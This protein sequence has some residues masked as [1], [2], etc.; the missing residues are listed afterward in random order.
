MAVLGLHLSP[1]GYR[2]LLELTMRHIQRVWPDQSPDALAYVHPPWPVAP[3][4]EP[5]DS[6]GP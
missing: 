2:T 5:Q 1:A 3:K 6:E 4:I